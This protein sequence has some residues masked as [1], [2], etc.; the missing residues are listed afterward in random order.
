MDTPEPIAGAP[1]GRRV[2]L[3]LLGLGVAG[4]FG[5]AQIQKQLAKVLGPL[6]NHDPTGLVGLIPVGNSFRFYSVTRGAPRKTADT[7]RLEVTGLVETPRTFTLADLD[8]MPQTDLVRDFQCVTGWRVPEVPWR[9]VR[10]DHI[11]EL[12]RPARVATAVR[13]TSFDGTYTESLTL[14]QARRS[15]VLVALE[16]IDGPVTHD[17]GGPVRLY[18]APMYG[19]KS[20]KWLSG[21]ELTADVERG[22]WEER[23]YDVDAWVGGSNGRGDDP[24]A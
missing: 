5:G 9:G 15:D 8:A 24:T 14:E 3:G 10:L 11:L 7:Y 2:V 20:L 6:G 21:I 1:V 19:Y 17:H 4:V 22:Y 16:M 18:V 12:V 23:G 13:F